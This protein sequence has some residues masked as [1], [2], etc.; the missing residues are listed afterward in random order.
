MEDLN[1]AA[2][3]VS[4]IAVFI[5]STV[6]YMAF[7]RQM[8]TLN[9]VYADQTRPPVGKVLL[10]LVRSAI[11]AIVVSWLVSRLEIGDLAEG[12]LLGLVLWVGFPVILLTGSVMWQREPARLAAIHAGDWLL[13]LLAIAAIVT[14][15][16]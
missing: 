8:A 9:P 12:L 10:E 14:L 11:L 6:Y 2:V 16:D 5:I 3:A 13:K 1:A 4:A 15:W 7:A